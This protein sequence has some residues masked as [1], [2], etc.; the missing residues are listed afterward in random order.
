MDEDDKKDKI[1]NG[2]KL[3][4]W[5]DNS[6]KFREETEAKITALEESGAE[7]DAEIARLKE[8]QAKQAEFTIIKKHKWEDE[9]TEEGKN[10]RFGKILYAIRNR[11][12]KTLAAMG[13]EKVKSD[14]R[15]LKTYSLG[16][17]TDL[18]DPLTGDAS[19]TD[20]QYA[21]PAYIYACN[22]F[23]VHTGRCK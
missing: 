16:Q 19:G 15:D 20:W 8:E 4:E 14:G 17:K 13:M 1:D 6:N 10:Y 18:G 7:K 3:Q 21:I 11:D 9:E 12:V 2:E 23:F 22:G 5:I